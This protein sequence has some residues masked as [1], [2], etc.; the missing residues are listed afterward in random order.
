[1]LWRADSRRVMPPRQ[2]PDIMCHMGK[3]VEELE[4]AVRELTVEERSAFRA[5]FAAF[6]AEEWDRQLESDVAKGRLDWLADEARRDLREGRCT[7][8]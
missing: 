3:K 8:R 6:D 1:L 5:W 4:E 7:D 2:T